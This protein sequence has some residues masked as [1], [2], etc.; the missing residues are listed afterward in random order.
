MCGLAGA[1]ALSNSRSNEELARIGNAMGNAIRHR[2]PD[3]D[4]E[5]TDAEAGLVL[6]FRRLA[7][8]DLSAAARQPMTSYGERFVILFNGE[9]YNFRDI[10][11][12]LEAQ[13]LTFEG[14]SDTRVLLEALASWGPDKTLSKLV[15]MFAFAL[16]DRRERTLLLARDRLGIKPMYWGRQ[17]SFTFFGSELKALRAH[18]DFV[19]RIDRTS[20]EQLVR[21]NYVP[22]PESIYRDI[23]QLEPGTY[24]TIDRDGGAR[25]VRYWDAFELASSAF[26]RRAALS[27]EVAE[28]AL[29]EILEDAIERRMIADVPLGVLLSGGIDSSLV[30]AIMQARSAKPIKTFSIGFA[31]D[32][33]NEAGHAKAIAAHLGTDHHEQILS[34]ED[35]LAVVPELPSIYCEPFAD[36]SQI[37]THLVSQMARRHVTVALSGDGGDE[38]FAGYNRYLAAHSIRPRLA[39]LPAAI[40]HLAAWMMRRTPGELMDRIAVLLP[41]SRRPSQI[42]DKA[43]KLADLFDADDTKTFHRRV[44]Q[45]WSG[46]PSFVIGAPGEDRGPAAFDRDVTGATVVE[47]M[48]L[49]DLLTYLPG[50]ILTKVDR[51]SMSVGLEARVPLLD[52]RIIEFSW[53]L[54][55][56]LKIRDGQ[57][58]W[59][60]RRVLDRHVPRH[61]TERPKAGFAVPLGTWLRGPLRD[62]AED[63]LS[64]ESLRDIGL[65]DAAPVREKWVRHL[66]GRD[67]AHYDLWSVLMTQAWA[68]A[69]PSQ[70]S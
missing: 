44:T 33:F 30:A 23:R 59:L 57:S 8:V 14:H 31:D 68:R 11:R 60:L 69:W 64:A 35:A 62:W 13:G 56:S 52:H 36:S 48:Q 58:K 16:W 12:E 39:Q 15:G 70:D 67:Q 22:G 47:T 46:A 29:A 21:F 65:F 7:I 49:V 50:D 61:L 2:G 42:G 34:P 28:E 17:G 55:E 5:W 54:P 63:L 24:V 32:E 26:G 3:D 38:V 19:P 51:A 41:K 9:I 18:P 20:V 37:P 4:A 6:A 43:R 10:R 25:H 1:L 66:S 27:P 40:R 53:T 45:F